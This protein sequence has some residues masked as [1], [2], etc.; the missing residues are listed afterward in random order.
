M[1]ASDLE[2]RRKVLEELLVL[3]SG[4]LDGEWEWSL[5]SEEAVTRW[6]ASRPHNTSVTPCRP[7]QSS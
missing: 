5:E 2:D 4:L 6:E 7:W 3:R 1:A